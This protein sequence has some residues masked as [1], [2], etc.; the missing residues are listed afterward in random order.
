MSCAVSGVDIPSS[1]LRIPMDVH[2]RSFI[3]WLCDVVIPSV[4]VGSKLLRQIH[5][6]T[7]NA[8][9]YYDESN[10]DAVDGIDASIMLLL[11]RE[12]YSFS[13]VD[14]SCDSSASIVDCIRSFAAAGDADFDQ[15]VKQY[16]NELCDDDQDNIPR[17]LHRARTLFHW[18]ASPAVKCGIVLKMLRVAL[19]SVQRPPD[20]TTLV[21]E[22]ITMAVDEND[23]S[24][25]QE[26]TRLLEINSLVKNYCGNGAQEFFRVSD[27]SHGL[28]LVHHV[29]CHIDVPTVFSNV[30]MLCNAFTHVSKLDACLSLI[31][32]TMGTPSGK[33]SLNHAG[34]CALFLHE[35]YLIDATLAEAVGKRMAGFCAGVLEDCKKMI[36]LKTFVVEAKRHAKVASSTACAMLSVMQD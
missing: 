32:R 19:V 2:P 5:S 21:K 28:K 3:P 14:D 35:I 33:A 17:A 11:V 30:L 9:D 1:A 36:L 10:D 4:A 26:A 8:A 22:A 31:Q 18:C 34:R 13:S 15:A 7:V 12:D 24:K 27:P 29:S 25:L 20:I 23:K 6:C 16:A